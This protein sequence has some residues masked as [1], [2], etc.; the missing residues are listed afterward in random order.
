MLRSWRIRAARPDAPRR[1]PLSLPS[2]LCI[3]LSLYSVLNTAAAQPASD[4]EVPPAPA[5]DSEAAEPDAGETAAQEIASRVGELY[6]EGSARFE[7]SDY[8]AAVELW[9]QAYALL[10]DDDRFLRQRSRLLLELA[11]AHMRAK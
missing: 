10:P 9:T 5:N 2:S 6:R 1:V 3:F 11:S 7:A 8:N 4:A